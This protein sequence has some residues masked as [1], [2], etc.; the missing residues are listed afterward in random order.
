MVFVLAPHGLLSSDAELVEVL[1]VLVLTVGYILGL[2]VSWLWK[3]PG[4]GL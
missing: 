1:L 3:L 2:F 4:L